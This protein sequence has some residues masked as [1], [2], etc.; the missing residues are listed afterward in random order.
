LPAR[1]EALKVTVVIP[2]YSKPVDYLREAI[3]SL[4][5]Q[6]VDNW[7]AIVVDD[8]NTDID[9]VD[10]VA[11][12]GDGRLRVVRHSL[13][14]G[15]GAA[16]NTGFRNAKAPLVAMLDAD[17]RLHPDYLRVMTEVVRDAPERTW[18]WPD[19]EVFGEKAGE[20]RFPDPPVSMC[21]AHIDYRGGSSLIP[22]ELWEAVGGFSED[23]L[24]SGL[25]ELDFW[26]GAV[27]A[28]AQPKYVH[29]LLYQW[30]VSSDSMTFQFLPDNHLQ[31]E[32]IHRRRRS[33]FENASP[34]PDCPNR[35]PG[36]VFRAIG[37]F[38]SSV[39]AFR[40]RQR[41]RSLKLGLQAWFLN[42]SDHAIRSHMAR[43]VAPGRITRPLGRLARLLGIRGRPTRD[44]R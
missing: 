8:G 17:D 25:E 18:V 6:T 13:N 15:I 33:L 23:P 36:S 14:R 11:S 32:E 16:R 10:V 39:H 21:P 1:T 12:I 42:P 29:D 44:R 30:R 28:G 7:E 35:D 43:V 3:D 20:W 5:A 24:L 41:L 31:M 40:S 34:C 38:N 22:V 27:E 4:I 19:I 26:M 9:L 37:Y 2:H